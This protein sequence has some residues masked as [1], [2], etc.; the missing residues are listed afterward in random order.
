MINVAV[1]HNRARLDV[2][3]EALQLWKDTVAGDSDV[4]VADV[5]EA[6]VGFNAPEQGPR[7]PGFFKPNE[8]IELIKSILEHVR[9]D[10]VAAKA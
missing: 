9:V 10:S 5:G 4:F 8:R 7:S 6:F 3:A 2:E 1:H